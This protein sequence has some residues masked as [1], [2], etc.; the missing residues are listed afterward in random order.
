V[1]TA[2]QTFRDLMAKKYHLKP[3]DMEK[4]L[5][6]PLFDESEILKADKAGTAIGLAWTNMGGDTLLVEAATIPGN[7]G[8]TLTGQLGEVMKESASI[9]LSWAR[10]YAITSN[11]T[12]Q[13][14]FRKNTIHLHIPEGA[15]PK[16]GP[17]AGITMTTALLSL[18]RQRPIKPDWAMTGELSLTGQVLPIGGLKEKTVAAKRNK[19]KHIIIPQRNLR[20]LEKIPAHVKKG[21]EFHPV[22]KMEEVVSLVF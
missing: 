9:A 1:E 4:Y 17:S 15:T 14:W 5:D 13:G 2:E 6:K 7:E 20:D 10:R 11:E 22:T 12:E 19:I 8:F 16:D 18:L 3:E 21:L